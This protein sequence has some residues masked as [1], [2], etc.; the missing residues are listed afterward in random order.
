MM[1]KTT[2]TK[3]STST[4]K[5]KITTTTTT[6]TVVSP[7]AATATITSAAIT[8]A[9]IAAMTDP[10]VADL[11]HSGIGKHV[12][13]IGFPYDDGVK[14]NGGRPG[15]AKGPAAFLHLLTTRRT[16]TAINPEKRISLTHL[17][18][19]LLPFIDASLPLEQAHAR[20]KTL[21]QL[22]LDQGSIPFVIGGG[23]DQSYPNASALLSHLESSPQTIGV[24]NIDA[25]LDVRPRTQKGEVHSGTPFREL[26]EDPRFASSPASR[27]HPR[28]V[29]FAAQGSQCAQSHVDYIHASNGSV[30]WLDEIQNHPRGASACFV[31]TL[32]TMSGEKL[33]ISFDLD[34]IHGG[35]A[36]GVSCPSP[37]GLSAKDALEI[38]FEAGKD[39]RVV[40]FD[41]SELN[42]E[43]EEYRSARLT[44]MMFNYFLLGL[45]KRVPVE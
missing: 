29:E 16:G 14:R 5:G 21:V 42:P 36:P 32:A 33:F 24:I 10:R 4:E 27:A 8:P 34:S 13:I 3:V 11:I 6:H 44:A 18:I 26:L 38:C 22:V 15:A 30:V 37:N 12:T 20:L 35:D 41:L 1:Q 45:A 23:N 28:L 43:V 7:T 9:T 17:D 39:P 25:H 40:L 19:G 31:D 2:T